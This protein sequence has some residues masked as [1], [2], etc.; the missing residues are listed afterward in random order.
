MLHV[1]R[2]PA[3]EVT[4]SQNDVPVRRKQIHS[5]ETL[6]TEALGKLTVVGFLLGRLFDLPREV[7]EHRHEMC[8]AEL[9]EGAGVEYFL[10]Q[11]L[12]P[13]APVRASE[14]KEYVLILFSRLLG[15]SLEIRLPLV[16]V[17]PGRQRYENQNRCRY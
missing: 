3:L 17:A 10:L 1:I 12:A 8:F 14:V 16:D 11:P 5:R 4:T 2:G 9:F 15:G 6:H 13:P 7:Y